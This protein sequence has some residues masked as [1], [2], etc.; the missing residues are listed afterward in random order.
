MARTSPSRALAA[1]ADELR[2]TIREHDWRYYVLDAPA[3]SDEAYDA[4]FA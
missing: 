4:L 3:V 1:R 2:R